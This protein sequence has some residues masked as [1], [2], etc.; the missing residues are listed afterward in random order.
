MSN[1]RADVIGLLQR[2]THLG[3]DI[4]QLPHA[5]MVSL[6]TSRTNLRTVENKAWQTPLR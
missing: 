6:R 1:L 3:N 2:L 5:E 4:R